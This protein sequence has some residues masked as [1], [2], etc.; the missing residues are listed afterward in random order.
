MAQKLATDCELRNRLV[1][2]RPL[3]GAQ[4]LQSGFKKCH[5][6]LST[7]HTRHVFK[8]VTARTGIGLHRTVRPASSLNSDHFPHDEKKVLAPRIWE[9]MLTETLSNP[10]QIPNSCASRKSLLPIS[11]DKKPACVFTP[12]PPFLQTQTRRKCADVAWLGPACAP[13]CG[14]LR[15]PFA[16]A[17]LSDTRAAFL[18]GRPLSCRIRGPRARLVRAAGPALR[19][20]CVGVG[21]TSAV[22]IGLI[23]LVGGTGGTDA[24]GGREVAFA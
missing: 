3:G 11:G 19:A 13:L 8:S 15:C 4:H 18:W 10:A 17:I 20:P 2:Q 5:D 1:I 6:K 24:G 21:Q 12:R 23:G 9:R 14:A 22:G 7:G 16:A